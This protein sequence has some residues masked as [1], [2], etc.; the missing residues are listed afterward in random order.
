MS[1][2]GVFFDGALDSTTGCLLR[3]SE[4]PRRKQATTRAPK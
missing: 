2:A 4:G 3:V 1:N